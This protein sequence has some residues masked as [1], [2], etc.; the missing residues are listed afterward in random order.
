MWDIMAHR[1][2]WRDRD[3]VFLQARA[4][5]KQLSLCPV[6]DTIRVAAL[7]LPGG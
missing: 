3:A 5:I 1:T 4:R 6:A 2:N 7:G